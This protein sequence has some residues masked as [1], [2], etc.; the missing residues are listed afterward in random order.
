VLT[1]S[2]NMSISP[3]TLP[4]PNNMNSPF[5]Q[6]FSAESA[7]LGCLLLE[8]TMLELTELDKER[9]WDKVDKSRDCWLWTAAKCHGYGQVSING[10]RYRPHRITYMIYKGE[11][12]EGLQINHHCDT[13][14][15]VNPDHL[16]AGTQKQNLI[17]SVSRGR[18][19][20]QKLKASDIPVIMSYKGKLSRRELGEIY[21]VDKTTIRNIFIGKTWSFVSG[22]TYTNSS[23][24]KGRLK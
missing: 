24:L 9:F 12:P 1:K 22:V 7:G 13:P 15:C 18:H 8:N 10:K 3:Q 6:S 2:I 19:H 23:I 4:S 14:L 17:D 21:G 16:Y 20:L 11:I 5:L